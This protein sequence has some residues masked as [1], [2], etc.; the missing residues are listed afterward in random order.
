VLPTRTMDR[1]LPLFHTKHL[2]HSHTGSG[3]VWS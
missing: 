1:S 3:P 2:I